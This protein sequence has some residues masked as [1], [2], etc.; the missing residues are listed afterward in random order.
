MSLLRIYIAGNDEFLELLNFTYL[1]W[2][3]SN[4]LSLIFF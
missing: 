1:T 3:L 2:E 4:V